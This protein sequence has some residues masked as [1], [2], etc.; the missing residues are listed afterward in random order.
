[1]GINAHD[2]DFTGDN[3][4]SLGAMAD[5]FY[6]YLPKVS[7]KDALCCIKIRANIDQEYLLLGGLSKDYQ[8]L[9]E[10]SIDA[11]KKHHFFRPLNPENLDILIA[12]G[13]RVDNGRAELDP[14]GQ[15]LVCFAG[16]MIAIGAKI[17]QREDLDIGRKLVNG[18][19]W[20]Y[21]SFSTGIMPETFHAIPCTDDCQWSETKWHDGVMSRAGDSQHDARTRIEQGRLPPGFTDIP[22]RRYIL[23]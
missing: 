20:A 14:Q 21:E 12:G 7:A 6:E 22:D 2:I 4:F 18:C 3:T 15:H 9:Y 19:V 10:G 13:V 17:F 11:A 16:G 8:T 23:R 1:M 5:S